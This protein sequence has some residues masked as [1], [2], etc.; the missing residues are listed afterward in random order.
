MVSVLIEDLHKV[1]NDDTSNND[2]NLWTQ[3]SALQM[4]AE[5]DPECRGHVV[6][7]SLIGSDHQ[8]VYT[9]LPFHREGSLLD[10]CAEVGRLNE[11][12]ARFFFCQILKVLPFMQMI[13]FSVQLRDL[14]IF[15]LSIVTTGT[16]DT[17]AG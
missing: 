13:L 15:F 9:I 5:K 4:I 17:A 8:H 6:G 1:F 10:Y 2:Q 11:N 7:T 16:G 12:E 14:N 3:L